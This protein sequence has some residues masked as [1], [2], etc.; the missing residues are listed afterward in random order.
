[1]NCSIYNS[2][3]ILKTLS[4]KKFLINTIIAFLIFFISPTDIL[5]SD[6]A[7]VTLEVSQINP[8][9]AHLIKISSVYDNASNYKSI[10]RVSSI[11]LSEEAKSG[12]AVTRSSMTIDSI[13]VNRNYQAA[14]LSLNKT[15]VFPRI[16]SPNGDGLNDIVFFVLDNPRLSRV[17]G[18]IFTL[19][20]E[21]VSDL[22]PTKSGIPTSDTL[23]W[24]GKDQDGSN[25]PAG[26]Y[27]Y[28]I[29]GEEKV[30]NGTVV[31]AR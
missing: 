23:I 22:K 2:T 21:E 3:F 28:Q 27:I 19:K 17:Q 6:P 4:I 7:P 20:G 24:D 13:S 8:D 16:F 30:I 25:V 18:K 9:Q 11:I 10:P 12:T 31:V 29:K 15:G 14:G 1:M 26:V 5:M